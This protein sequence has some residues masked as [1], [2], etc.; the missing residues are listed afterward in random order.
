MPRRILVAVFVGLAGLIP[1]HGCAP[2]LPP[3][4]PVQG[5]VLLNGQPLPKAA[6]TF[7]P[8]LDHFGAESNSTAETDENGQFT[9]TCAY[10][11][12]PGAV[13]GKHIVLVAEPPP[14]ENMRN[15]Q[16]GRVLDNYRAK[17]G[18]RP[19]PPQYSSVSQSPI[20][21]EIKQGQEPVTIE[22]TRDR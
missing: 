7:V 20:R 9:L 4:V 17:L 13:I 8:L 10:N 16:D 6:V 18:N 11:N 14:P 21:I 3:V 19:I 12:Q 1:L 15:V 2:R 5:K 22:L